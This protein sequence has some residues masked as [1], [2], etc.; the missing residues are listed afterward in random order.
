M[1]VIHDEYVEEKGVLL[2]PEEYSLVEHFLENIENVAKVRDKL[3]SLR[4]KYD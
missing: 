1:R 4:R 2:T 3:E